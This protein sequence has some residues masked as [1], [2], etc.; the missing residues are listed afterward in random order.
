MFVCVCVCVFLHDNSKRNRSRNTKLKYIVVYENSSD[1]FDI[2]LHLIKVQVTVGLQKFST[3]QTVRSY[4][5]TL[6]QAR[7]LI[8]SI[9]VHRIVI[10]KIYECRHA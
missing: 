9:W 3:I 1:E 10:Q 6:V 2:E 5:S 8:L 4:N 7:K